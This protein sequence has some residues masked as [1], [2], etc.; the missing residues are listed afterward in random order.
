MH[1]LR[2]AVWLFGA[3]IL[4][5]CGA[6]EPKWAPDA[7]VA[8]SVYRDDG[9]PALTLFTVVGTRSGSG[10]HSGLMVS[11]PSQ[12]ALFDPAGTFYHPH[13]PERNDV[14]FGISDP[15]VAFYID[16]HARIT[17]DVIEQTIPVSAAV[18][19]L[20]LARIQAY[21]AVAKAHCSDSITEILAGLPGFEDAPQTMFPKPV[22][23]WFGALEGVSTTVHSD[24]SPDE[25]G[26][27]VQAPPL[28]LPQ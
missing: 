9:P 19:E 1:R 27:L 4:T 18:A 3:L 16:Y 26:R 25:N 22:M 2:L 17:Y 15:A 10:A 21:G 8:R 5:A 24:D 7:E 23:K 20:A 6:P 13:L 14:H 11:A 12:R 28:L